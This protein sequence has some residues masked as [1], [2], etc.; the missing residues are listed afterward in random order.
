MTITFCG[1]ARQVTGSIYVIEIENGYRLL[2]DCG[3]DMEKKRSKNVKTEPDLSAL[4]GALFPFEASGIHAVVLTHAHLDHTGMI[5]NL[6]REGFEGT[7]YCTEPTL[8][9]TEILL[10]DSASINKSKLVAKQT[11][12]LSKKHRK[13]FSPKTPDQSGLFLQDHVDESLPLFRSVAFGQSVKLSDG[14][15]FTFL[16]AGHLLGAAHIVITFVED[17]N[18]K[19]IGFSGDLGRYNYPLLQDPEPLPE[20]DYLVCEGTYGNRLHVKPNGPEEQLE[21]I[22]KRTCLDKPGRLIIPAFS[23]GRTQALLYTL[24]RLYEQDRLPRIKVFSDSPMAM[25]STLVYQKYVNWLN[26]EARSFYKETDHLFDFEYL[27]YI[28]DAK[29]S[30]ELS[31]HNEPCIIISS[32][33]MMSGGRVEYHIRQNLQNA[34]ATI[35]IIGYCAEGTLGHQL[36]SGKKYFY[37]DDKRVDIHAEVVQTDVFSG[38]GD[39]NDLIKFIKHQPKD[40]LKQLFLT[41][42]DEQS[43]EA[44]S[45][46]IRQ[47]HFSHVHVPSK[48]QVFEL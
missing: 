27:Q 19:R 6:V 26:A 3:L 14:L 37:D 15:K 45:E 32:S 1:A 38:H 46:F 42:G 47:E 5:P 8:A 4:S 18:E 21:E 34:F 31:N 25:S 17:G 33:G 12:Y 40:K 7:I 10:Y 11:A 2:V 30:K 35:L 44:F 16:K 13:G 23:V 36:I 28:H 39:L 29:R 9:L 43:L 24:K 22:I 41:H 48:G 20:L